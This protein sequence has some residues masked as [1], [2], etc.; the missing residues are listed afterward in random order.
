MGDPSE[1]ASVGKR[2]K[3]IFFKGKPISPKKRLAE[4]KKLKLAE[5]LAELEENDDEILKKLDEM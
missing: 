4:L 1:F 3:P 2:G 5:K